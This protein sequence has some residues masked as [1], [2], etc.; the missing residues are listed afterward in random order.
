MQPGLGDMPLTPL[1]R[2]VLARSDHSTTDNW[3]CDS[4]QRWPHQLVDL[5]DMDRSRIEACNVSKALNCKVGAS[6][7]GYA[8]VGA[9]LAGTDMI[10]HQHPAFLLHNIM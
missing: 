1:K 10:A 2:D 4:W 7:S 6:V 8:A 5:G 9:I 3:N